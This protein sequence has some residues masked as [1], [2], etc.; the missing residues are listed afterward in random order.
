MIATGP[1]LIL[2][3]DTVAGPNSVAALQQHAQQ[4][5]TAYDLVQKLGDFS[6]GTREDV[7]TVLKDFGISPGAI[8]KILGENADQVREQ[9]KAAADEAASMTDLVTINQET[10]DILS[11]LL[12]VMQGKSPSIDLSKYSTANASNNTGGSSTKPSAAT[13]TL[14]PGSYPSYRGS[15]DVVSAVRENTAIQ[16]QQ[17]STLRNVGRYVPTPRNT[18]NITQPAY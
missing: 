5:S 10:N 4:I 12:D 9:I 16:R 18:R 8:G 3:K 7:D 15:P 2:T 14:P 6:F 13:G 11:D 17:L 1:D